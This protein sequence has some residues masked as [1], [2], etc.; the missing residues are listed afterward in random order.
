MKMPIY[1][2]EIIAAMLGAAALTAV[3]AA[4]AGDAG[5][6]VGA[7]A[8]HAGYAAQATVINTVHAHLHHTVNCLVGPNGAGFDAKELNPCKGM[9]DGAIADTADAAKKK[10]LDAAL[11]AANAGLASNDLTAAK[12]AAADAEAALKQAM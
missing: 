7:A 11:A 12:Q 8:Q 3:S 4:F 9:G 5:K 6:E 1:S 2:R 10:A